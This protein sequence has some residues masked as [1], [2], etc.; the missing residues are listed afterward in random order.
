MDVSPFS[1]AAFLRGN[2]AT[3]SGWTPA[4]PARD[5]ASEPYPPLLARWI[6]AT[7]GLFLR[8]PPWLPSHLSPGLD[9]DPLEAADL[10][11]R[12]TAMAAHLGLQP[13]TGLLA[14][15]LAGTGSRP[16]GL[17]QASAGPG[18]E[19]PGPP[20]EAV[21]EKEL[22][23][24]ADPAW[25]VPL[26][27][28][29]S[30]AAAAIAACDDGEAASAP[31]AA[32]VEIS[33]R[34]RVLT[35]HAPGVE[36]P[37]CVLD[38]SGTRHRTWVQ[39]EEPERFLKPSFDM[40]WE[41]LAAFRRVVPRDGLMGAGW[42]AR[43]DVPDTSL[44]RALS[45]VRTVLR[46]DGECGIALTGMPS[47]GYRLDDGLIHL[48]EDSL[49]VF[50]HVRLDSFG[51]RALVDGKLEVHVDP[52]EASLVEFLFANVGRSFSRRQMMEAVWGEYKDVSD[53]M[54]EHLFS[55]VRSKLG[56]DAAHG[57][58]LG[59]RNNRCQLTDLTQGVAGQ[60]ADSL[61][62]VGPAIVDPFLRKAVVDGREAALAPLE[63]RFAR[64][65]GEHANRP[66]LTR[67]MI[68]AA[69]GEG[70][71]VSPTMLH[72]V[73]SG[74]RQALVLD[75]SR[76]W[77]L[78][79]RTA[80]GYRLRDLSLG[81]AGLPPDTL[82]G[83]Q[84]VTLDPFGE[85]ALVDGVE[86]PLEPMEITVARWL[87]DHAGQ[88]HTYDE[89]LESI[90]GEPRAI[91][92]V[93][94][95]MLG[96]LGK[97]LALDRA[98]GLE[99][100]MSNDQYGLLL[101]DGVEPQWEALQALAQVD[102]RRIDHR[103]GRSLPVLLAEILKPLAWQVRQRWPQPAQDL[104]QA[105]DA[106]REG[107]PLLPAGLAPAAIDTPVGRIDLTRIDQLDRYLALPYP[108]AYATLACDLFIADAAGIAPVAGGAAAFERPAAIDALLRERFKSR[109]KPITAL[110]L[111]A[112][113]SDT[114]VINHFSRSWAPP[115][116]GQ[117]LHAGLRN[118]I[119]ALAS[120]HLISERG[121]TAAYR[122]LGARA[123]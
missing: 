106:M 49:T 33:S 66:I 36:A 85:R 64:A 45:S 60:P 116:R 18:G 57:L 94:G 123:R 53:S 115:E 7:D 111:Q 76:G 54:I 8:P 122:S 113:W 15:W 120:R 12:F 107:R 28:A 59:W 82:V 100:R 3:A 87:F 101:A 74:V 14:R 119:G 88:V 17:V 31:P 20:R 86:V 52:L 93:R 63:W 38:R 48:P 32:R 56:L 98:H 51:H 84:H 80:V 25:R 11:R 46:L 13:D 41:L 69:W 109:Y 22:S 91:R 29:P 118:F 5:Q 40:A 67:E 97:A 72:H 6:S 43:S 89:L 75:G 4:L 37:H 73:S 108:L 96:P 2:P 68:D 71:E 83:F 112:P 34:G 35:L 39:G 78:E 114:L 61:V 26:L 70:E 104:A 47:V 23:W 62:R 105:A 102:L 110:P 30:S 65:L 10:W 117:D 44:K 19:P 50:K 16:S 55:H 77:V 58:D 21:E 27:V 81:I 121:M 42:P 79:G 9:L 103:A 92:Y 95:V 1:A 24:L 99:L 90:W